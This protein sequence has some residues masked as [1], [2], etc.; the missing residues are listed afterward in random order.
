[1]KLRLRGTPSLPPVTAGRMLLDAREEAAARA[2]AASVVEDVNREADGS[3]LV[4]GSEL[5]VAAPLMSATMV[6]GERPLYSR[7]AR[8]KST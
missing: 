6:S 1:M 7:R 3:S 4:T 5:V 8:S 2:G